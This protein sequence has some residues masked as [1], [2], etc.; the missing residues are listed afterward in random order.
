MLKVLVAV[1][2]SENSLRTVDYLL[3]LARNSREPFEA[4]VLNVQPPVTF[5]DIK[6]FIGHDALNRY[7][8]DEGERALAGARS[9]LAA[10]NVAHTFHIAVG[11]VAETVVQYARE[12]GCTQIVLGTHGLGALSGLLGSVAMKVLHLADVPV[13][14]VK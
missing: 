10:A 14:L 1:D 4:H 13:T 12:H 2:G 5:G 11:P 9:R 6:K 7:Y 3:M 8:H